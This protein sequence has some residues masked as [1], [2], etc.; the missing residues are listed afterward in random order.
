MVGQPSPRRHR[1]EGGVEVYSGTDAFG[2]LQWH[3]R[4]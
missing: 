3:R 1:F 2:N 4:L